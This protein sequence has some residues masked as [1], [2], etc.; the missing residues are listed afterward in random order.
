[1]KQM[2][3]DGNKLSQ[4]VINVRPLNVSG[5]GVYANGLLVK[6]HKSEAL[7]LEHAHRLESF[8]SEDCA[9][10]STMLVGCYGS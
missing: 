4:V 7:A 6:Q 2:A 5:Y 10:K 1:M 8:Q 9:T 3:L